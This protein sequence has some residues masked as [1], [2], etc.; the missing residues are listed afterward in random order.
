MSTNDKITMIS[1]LSTM[2]TAGIPILESI[3]SL[4]DGSKGNQKIVLETLKDDLIQGKRVYVTM[5]KFPKIFDKVT[6][7]IVKASEEAG[8]LNVTLNDIVMIIRKDSEFGDKVKSAMVYP[9]FILGVFVAVFLMILVV[10]VPKISTVF[11]RMDMELPL[12]TQI[13]IFMSD[14]LMNNTIAFI[15]G[16]SLFVFILI[17]L[18]KKNRKF[19]MGILF[20]LPVISLLAREI[21]LTRFTRSLF[22]LLSAGIPITSALELCQDIVSK[23]EVAVAIIHAKESVISGK[24]ISDGMK[25]YK[26][27]IPNVIIKIIEAGERTGSLDKSMQDCSDYLEYQVANSLKLVTTLIEPI[28]LVFVGIAIGGMML[29]I[30]APIYQMIGQVGS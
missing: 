5:T 2:L 24:K 14:I 19:M 27:I 22:L 8:T 20:S 11:K 23:K 21:D 16:L 26:K 4:L 30:I 6:V 9:V 1:N 17:I 18:Y 3:D 25:D 15:L 28:M 12:P 13:L 29:S 7:N 10:V